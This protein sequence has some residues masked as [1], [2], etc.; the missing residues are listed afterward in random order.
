MRYVHVFHCKTIIQESS[1]L[2]GNQQNY[3]EDKQSKKLRI[4]IK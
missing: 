4:K 1:I 2:R 3:L